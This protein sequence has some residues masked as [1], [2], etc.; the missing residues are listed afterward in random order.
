MYDSN[1][2]LKHTY[3]FR[4]LNGQFDQAAHIEQAARVET[5]LLCRAAI[6][7]I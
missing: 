5:T 7:R 3:V 4:W 6:Q 2:R 1:N